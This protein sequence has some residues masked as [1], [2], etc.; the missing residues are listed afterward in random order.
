MKRTRIPKILMLTLLASFALLGCTAAQ[1]T[2]TTELAS[3]AATYIGN[4][5]ATA[6]IVPEQFASLSVATAGVVELITIREG[7]SIELVGAQLDAQELLAQLVSG[8]VLAYR[9]RLPAQPLDHQPLL[10][11]LLRVV[12]TGR[13][14][15]DHAKIEDRISDLG[16]GKFG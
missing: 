11:V 6:K 2:E 8:G 13:F 9:R 1:E 10:D 5:S 12:S 4:I 14:R 15:F 7:D 3:L 16:L